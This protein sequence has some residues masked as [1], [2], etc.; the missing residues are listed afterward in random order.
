MERLSG[1]KTRQVGFT[2]ELWGFKR[3]KTERAL[4][5]QELGDSPMLRN[6]MKENMMLRREERDSP[7][8]RELGGAQG[9]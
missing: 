9:A 5:R 2:K 4:G 3:W 1:R 8:D 6:S 7:K